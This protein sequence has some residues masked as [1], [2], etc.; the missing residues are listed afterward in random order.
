MKIALVVNRYHHGY[1]A[2][3]LSLGLQRHTDI[4]PEIVSLNPPRDTHERI[5]I[6]VP[7]T[8]FQEPTGIMD[9]IRWLDSVLQPYDCILTFHTKSGLF[10]AIIGKHRGI[11][12]ISREGNNHH[13]FSTS[14]RVTRFFTGI[15]ADR[16]VCVS[17]SVKTSYHGFERVIP[18]S[19]FEVIP[20]GVDTTAVENAKARDWTIFEETSCDP[21]SFI[22]GTAGSLTTQKNHETL[23]QAIAKLVSEHGEHFELVIAGDGPRKEALRGVA[24]ETGISDSIHFLGYIER[25]HVYKLLHEIDCYA[26]PSRWEGH[27]LAVLQAMAAGVPCVLSDIPSF[28]AQY[29][30]DIVDF[31]PTEDVTKLMKCILRVQGNENEMGERVKGFVMESYQLRETA[32]R[33][34]STLEKFVPSQNLSNN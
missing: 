3:D 11:P 16:I 8:E 15:L 5:S 2:T 24:A 34:E 4:Q 25:E 7:Q 18:K 17:E 14:V 1:A 12:V 13:H 29:I 6:K 26:M 27:S 31:Y 19:K 21:Q 22:V 32:K 23:I 9:E 30:D 20:N 33:Y 10:A 28:R